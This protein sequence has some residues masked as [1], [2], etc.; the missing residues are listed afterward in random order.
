[1]RHISEALLLESIE[2]IEQE[3]KE[4]GELRQQ[5][6]GQLYPS[7]LYSEI[8][9]LNGRCS[10]LRKRKEEKNDNN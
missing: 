3:V 1:M 10:D 2:E 5:M 8:C 7:I 4:R 6:V 9:Q